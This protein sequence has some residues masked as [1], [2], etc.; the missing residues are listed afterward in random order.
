MCTRCLS[1][2]SCHTLFGFRARFVQI[3]FS[4]ARDSICVACAALRFVG[5]QAH[6]GQILTNDLRVNSD[7][8]QEPCF[9]TP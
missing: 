5:P 6:C 2:Q 7:S 4:E 8:S 3:T 1:V 9:G